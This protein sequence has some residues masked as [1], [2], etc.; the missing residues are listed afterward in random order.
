MS[1]S[2][3]LYS[4]TH[5]QIAD[6]IV[7]LGPEQK[8]AAG[9]SQHIWHHIE[10]LKGRGKT[11]IIHEV[12]RRL[13]NH[14][15]RYVD[16]TSLTTG[17]IGIP[18]FKE[19]DEQD[20]VRFVANEVLGIH[21]NQP[22]IVCLDELSK[23]AREVMLPLMRAG[24]ERSLYDYRFH[25]DTVFFS[26][27]NLGIEG[28]GDKF[29]PHQLDRFTTVELRTPT[30]DEW[31][32][33]FAIPNGLNTIVCAVVKE[34]PQVLADWR[35][36]PNPDD[37]EYIDHPQAAGRT[38][39]TTPRGLAKAAFIM[40]KA[41]KLDDSTVQANL[42]GT[43]GVAGAKLV[44]TYSKLIDQLP[45]L[46]SIKQDPHNAKIPTTSGA[47]AM[48]AYRSLAAIE[49]DWL[50]EWMTYLLRMDK[51]AQAMF[52]IGVR[53]P[54]FNKKKQSYIMQNKQFT[55]WCIDNQHLFA[56]DKV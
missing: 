43:I 26:T 50:D 42:M 5:D 17:D 23:A 4:Q 20:F 41:G 16:C 6:A 44:M 33:N 2:E 52:C 1:F 28:L 36:V 3:R 48:V 29:Q 51:D 14:M 56:A 35:D 37:N 46:E 21:T 12:A 34:N 8:N 10:G 39:G 30:N 9:Y 19:A 24:L 32:A 7:E 49:R 18:K 40:D 22:L 47:A 38:K 13:P 55:Q 53:N 11:S 27:G 45:S 54:K 31:L 25:P 15:V